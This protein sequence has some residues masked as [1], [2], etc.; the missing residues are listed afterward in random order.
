MQRSKYKEKRTSALVESNVLVQDESVEKV[1]LAPAMSR[2]PTSSFG[3]DKEFLI[4]LVSK[5]C[6]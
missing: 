5:D 3:I 1:G 6:W 4:P 2:W